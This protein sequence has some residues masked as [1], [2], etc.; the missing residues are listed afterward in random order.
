MIPV[1]CWLCGPGGQGRALV[2]RLPW[3]EGSGPSG[4]QL[5]PGRKL[6]WPLTLG[7]LIGLAREP[8]KSHG[9]CLVLTRAR[10]P[11]TNDNQVTWVPPATAARSQPRGQWLWSP[12]ASVWVYLTFIL[13]VR[14]ARMGPLLQTEPIEVQFGLSSTQLRKVLCL[15]GAGVGARQTHCSVFLPGLSVSLGWESYMM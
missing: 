11:G 2:W 12:Q 14:R 4:E 13:A 9:R 15:L 8:R 10:W 3:P 1:R 7:A 6:D 5:A